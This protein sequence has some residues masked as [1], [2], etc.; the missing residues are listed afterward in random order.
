MRSLEKPNGQT[1][2]WPRRHYN[3]LAKTR[4]LE[5]RVS[6]AWDPLG[7]TCF[8]VLFLVPTNSIKTPDLISQNSKKR[9]TQKRLFWETLVHY[10]VA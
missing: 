10:T 2:T 9:F 7:P 8:K 4:G 5:L 3:F 1:S 6:L